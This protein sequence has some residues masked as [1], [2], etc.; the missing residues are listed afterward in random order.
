[1]WQWVQNDDASSSVIG[2]L[3]TGDR[4]VILTND[5]NGRPHYRSVVER[6][7]PGDHASLRVE[8]NQTWVEHYI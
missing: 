3:A 8:H 7:P 5:P 6:E 1:V 2:C 4:V